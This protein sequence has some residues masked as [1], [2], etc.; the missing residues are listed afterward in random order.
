M[1]NEIKN[2]TWVTMIT[3][4]TRE[5]QIDYPGVEALIE[6]YI[7]YKVDGIFAVCQSSEMFY[8]SLRERVELAKFVVEKARG[9]IPVVVSGHVSESIE[10]QR[11]KNS[12]G[13][14]R[15][16]LRH[17]RMPLSLQTAAHA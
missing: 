1:S 5:N 3:P 12:G 7:R 11:T 6:W 17:L 15:R 14:P 13:Y 8:L 16:K 9:R 2:G 4:F 10:S